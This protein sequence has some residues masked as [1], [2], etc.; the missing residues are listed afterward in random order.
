MTLPLNLAGWR[1][2]L[3]CSPP[4]LAE[5]AAVRYA[6]F[7]TVATADPAGEE[8][9]TVEVQ[10]ATSARPDGLPVPMLLAANL[11]PA[12]DA[13]LLDAAGI[14]GR[15]VLKDR[16]ALLQ[17]NG[18]DPLGQLEYF[19][20]I[21]CALLAYHGGGL[22]IHAAGLRAGSA[23]HLFIGQSG[24]GKSTVV[25]LSP[26]ALAL[27]DDLVLLR[28]AAD[29]WQAYGTPFWNQATSERSGETA[30]G[31]V[32][33]IYK[34]VQDRNVFIE[35]LPPAVAVAELLANCPVVN[36]VAA[37]LPG[38]VSRCRT[39]ARAMP[40]RALHFRKAPDFWQLIR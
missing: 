21:V 37:D 2:R 24:S 1:I 6:S 40:V 19:L 25:A 36:G 4:D 23:V 31:P 13:Y 12:E 16:Q 29:G 33:G 11:V 8:D 3:I 22:L 9:W 35:A 14:H 15:I 38:L 5:R 26:G 34:L 27:S 39:L 17:Y 32:A 30:S 28:P 7:A 20:R 18:A 10:A